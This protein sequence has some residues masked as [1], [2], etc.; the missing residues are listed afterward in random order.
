MW[1]LQDRELN[2]PAK[3]EAEVSWDEAAPQVWLWA[4]LLLQL[5]DDQE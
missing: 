2:Q 5:I 3:A 4:A 1:D